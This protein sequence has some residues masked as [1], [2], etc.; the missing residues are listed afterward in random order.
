MMIGTTSIL[1]LLLAIGTISDTGIGASATADGQDGVAAVGGGIRRSGGDG[2]S[3]TRKLVTTSCADQTL[4]NMAITSGI[5]IVPKSTTC[6]L[7]GTSMPYG[8][9]ILENGANLY[10]TNGASVSGNILVNDLEGSDTITP[11]NITIEYDSIVEGSIK[12]MNSVVNGL[13]VVN[14]TVNDIT[15]TDSTFE[16]DIYI[17]TYEPIGSIYVENVETNMLYFG[18]FHEMGD[19][20]WNKVTAYGNAILTDVYD[21]TLG[22]IKSGNV[23][24]SNCNFH[25][26]INWIR[27][28]TTGTVT[29]RD[30]HVYDESGRLDFEIRGGTQTDLTIENIYFDN[31]GHGM[32][33]R[34]LDV[35]ELRMKNLYVKSISVSYSD[36]TK[37]LIEDVFST[38]SSYTT[39]D[40]SSCVV[41]DGTGILKVKGLHNT[42]E[43]GNMVAVHLSNNE[44]GYLT[45]VDYST[46]SGTS[47]DDGSTSTTVY[48]KDN[49]VEYKLK[50]NASI[51]NSAW[52]YG[53]TVN[54]DGI[55]IY[56]NT[57]TNQMLFY[58][59]VVTAS[60]VGI[61]EF[62]GNDFD[63][64][65]ATLTMYDNEAATIIT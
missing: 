11:G 55:K 65:D 12:I 3:T 22:Y 16:E 29:V 19:V 8:N 60:K 20:Y 1:L 34:D 33:I 46:N 10:M 23:L 21:I 31:G 40:V 37:I 32:T 28:A 44:V 59:N 63:T 50:I 57:I 45:L 24:V 39:I 18:V 64:Y 30:V 2:H 48:V 61:I 38:A 42:V 53:N 43:D 41:A 15:I 27:I 6:T 51:F 17:S 9:V 36:A 14:S 62:S 49:I 7:D 26:R 35:G 54:Q 25:E 52:I 47:D 58:E 4:L 5:L 56:D 13:Y